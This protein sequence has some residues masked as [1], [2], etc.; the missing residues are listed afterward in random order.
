[1]RS[2]AAHQDRR[3]RTVDAPPERLWRVVAGLGG[4][5]GWP[6]TSPAWSLRGALDRLVG[7]PGSPRQRRDPDRLAPGDPVDSWVVEQVESGRRL[8][9]RSTMRLPGTARLE[10]LVEPAAAGRSRLV[11][12]ASFVPDGWAGTAYWRAVAPLH[13]A[14]F[15][16]LLAATARAAERPPP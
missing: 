16:R 15:G 4:E 5:R 2:P 13:S 10:L 7:G 14:V 3:S 11:Q 1:M 8:L 9:L 12:C 6:G